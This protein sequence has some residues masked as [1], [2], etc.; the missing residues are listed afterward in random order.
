LVLSNRVSC[1]FGWALA[2]SLK[3]SAVLKLVSKYEGEFVTRGCL[4]IHR[5]HKNFHFLAVEPIE[6]LAH[7]QMIRVFVCFP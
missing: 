6:F 3:F 1:G 4:E 7:T 5:L 2:A